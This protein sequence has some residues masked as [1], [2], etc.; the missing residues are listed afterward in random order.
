MRYLVQHFLPRAGLCLWL[1]AFLAPTVPAAELGQNFWGR[2]Y[3]PRLFRT[4]GGNTRRLIRA[5]PGGLRVTLPGGQGKRL[6]VGLIPRTGIRGDF[7]ITMA[8]ELLWVERPTDGNGAGVSIWISLASPTRKAATIAR[9]IRPDG[10]QLYI[11]NWAFTAAEG[12]REFHGGK[13]LPTEGRSGKL[14]L[15]RKGPS[16]SYQVSQRESNDFQEV[17]QTNLGTEDLDTVRFAADNGG[18]PTVVDVHINGVSIWTADDFGPA[19][20]IEQSSPGWP[21]WV[22]AGVAVSLFAACGGW[23]W[24]RRQRG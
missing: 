12:K 22:A 9:L 4:T 7:E 23:L 2:N 6:P 14:R 20:T 5:E 21:I 18:S 3:D 17:Y 1:V 15:V 24:R 13:P 19:R 8:F 16:L 11:S 10:E